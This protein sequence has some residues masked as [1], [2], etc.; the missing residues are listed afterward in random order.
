MKNFLKISIALLLVFTNIDTFA[1]GI[2][3]QRGSNNILEDNNRC[4]C[5]TYQNSDTDEQTI[6]EFFP[7]VNVIEGQLDLA[8]D[9][10]SSPSLNAVNALDMSS[11]NA[12]PF[13]HLIINQGR[14]LFFKPESALTMG[15]GSTIQINNAKLYLAGNFRSEK[16][17]TI[18][19]GDAESDTIDDSYFI[20]NARD[21]LYISGL[22]IN[23]NTERSHLEVHGNDVSFTDCNINVKNPRATLHLYNE[24]FENV[25]FNP[26]V[27]ELY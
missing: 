25:K 4:C 22:T 11:E 24:L 9:S 6:Q 20:I 23:L 2:L 18:N 10:I 3:R 16:T 26:V 15:S 21:P 7:A 27:S 1:S 17:S 13:S 19:I 12:Q 14:T 5:T 8:R